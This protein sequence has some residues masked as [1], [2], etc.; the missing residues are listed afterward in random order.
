MLDEWVNGA[1]FLYLGMAK[2]CSFVS[3]GVCK[4]IF[5]RDSDQILSTFLGAKSLLSF[6]MGKIAY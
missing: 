4:W 2:T 1:I 5:S 3:V 6:F